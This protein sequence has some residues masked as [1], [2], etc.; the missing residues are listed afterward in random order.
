VGVDGYLKGN[1]GENIRRDSRI[2]MSDGEI[3]D[4]GLL[5]GK[6]SRGRRGQPEDSWEV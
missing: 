3:D 4:E 5:S 1:K 2:R 6:T